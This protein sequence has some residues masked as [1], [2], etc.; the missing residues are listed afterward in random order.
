MGRS[1]SRWLWTQRTKCVVV[2]NTIWDTTYLHTISALDRFTKALLLLPEHGG[3]GGIWNLN[4]AQSSSMCRP[5]TWS[6]ISPRSF[7]RP[8]L[9]SFSSSQQQPSQ[10]SQSSSSRVHEDAYHC[11]LLWSVGV[12]G[13]ETKS[14]VCDVVGQDLLLLKDDMDECGLRVYGGV[15]EGRDDLRDSR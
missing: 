14:D 9:N 12:V 6:V 15:M 10:H 8:S 13:T 1:G 4:G 11:K 7:L 5:A 3:V 2:Y